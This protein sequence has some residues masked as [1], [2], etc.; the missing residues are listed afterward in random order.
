MIVRRKDK[1]ESYSTIRRRWLA[2]V[3]ANGEDFQREA[4]PVVLC[5]A[6]RRGK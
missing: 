5:D 3:L 4:A 1:P 6:R 2:W